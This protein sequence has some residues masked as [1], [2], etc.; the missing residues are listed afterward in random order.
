MCEFVGTY[1]L[2][3][4]AKKYNKKND[5]WLYHDDGFAVLKNK[6]GLQSEQVKKNIHKIFDEHGFVTIQCNM[7]IVNYLHVPFNSN[8]GT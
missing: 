1:T 6:S 4:L 8:D 2:D 3:L 5:F 7:K